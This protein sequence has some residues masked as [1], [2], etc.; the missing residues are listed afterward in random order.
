MC[1]SA[2]VRTR[3]VSV[4]VTAVTPEDP[5]GTRRATGAVVLATAATG[6]SRVSAFEDPALVAMFGF[7]DVLA[8]LILRPETAAGPR[9][10]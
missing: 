8:D 5:Y 6:V 1:P 9:W 2:N 10:A 4:R 7:R 3:P